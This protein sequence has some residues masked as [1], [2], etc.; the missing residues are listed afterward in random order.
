MRLRADAFARDGNARANDGLHAGQ[1]LPSQ[2]RKH[3]DG[4]TQIT[5]ADSRMWT[6]YQLHETGPDEL[7]IPLARAAVALD[8]I[9]CGVC[10]A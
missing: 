8:R 2:G 3:S 1:L 9:G 6:P 10:L 4:H 7:R 5:Y